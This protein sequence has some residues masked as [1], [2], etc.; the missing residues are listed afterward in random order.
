Q[1]VRAGQPLLQLDTRSS[2]S[3]RDKALGDQQAAQLQA[4][5]SRALIEAIDSGRAPRLSSLT[6]VPAAR[7]LD[8]ERHL[9]DQ[10]RDF[11]AKRDRLDQDIARY[12]EALPLAAQRAQDYAALARDH[13]VS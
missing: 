3:E 9:E 8:A 10:W 11:V 7:R 12:A 6:D 5:R 2:D 4:A 13:D 1:A